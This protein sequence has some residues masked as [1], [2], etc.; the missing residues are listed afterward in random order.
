LSVIILSDAYN[1]A[2]AKSEA[3]INTGTLRVGRLDFIFIITLFRVVQRFRHASSEHLPV[4]FLKRVYSL[5][6]GAVRPK[7]WIPRWS[8]RRTLGGAVVG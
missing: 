1:G 4:M 2:V 5:T 3:A 7:G 6:F 8:R